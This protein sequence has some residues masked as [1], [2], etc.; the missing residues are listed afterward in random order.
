MYIYIKLSI[1]KLS[2]NWPSHVGFKRIWILLFT[3]CKT[4]F[5][6]PKTLKLEDKEADFS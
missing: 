4:T 1:L 3:V 6:R 5:K 2:I